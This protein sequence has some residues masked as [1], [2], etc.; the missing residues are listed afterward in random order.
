[1]LEDHAKDGTQ[2]AIWEVLP[3]MDLLL[4]HLEMAKIDYKYSPHP[5]LKMIVNNT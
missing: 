3:S 2:G 1:L 5:Y 4:N